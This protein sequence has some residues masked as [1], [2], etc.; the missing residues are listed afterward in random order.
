MDFAS[1]YKEKTIFGLDILPNR[2]KG[3]NFSIIVLKVS[4]TTSTNNERKINEYNEKE[5]QENLDIPEYNEKMT[6]ITAINEINFYNLIGLIRKNRPDIIAI[7]N[8]TELS[9]NKGGI[10]PFAKKIPEKCQ[11]IQVTGSPRQ[12]F[13]K[14]K[15]LA[16][17]YGIRKAGLK[18][19]TP[20]ET[21]EIVAKLAAM[22]IG[23]RMVAFEDE[24]KIAVSKSR[25][26]GKGGWSAPRYERNMKISVLNIDKEIGRALSDNSIDFDHFVYP[27]R[28]IFIVRPDMENFTLN[29]F[30]ILCKKLG[31]DLADVRI[32]RIPKSSIEFVPLSTNAPS[33][34]S[35]KIIKSI[36]V[37]VDPGTTTGLAIIDIKTQK[38]IFLNSFRD[39]GTS[40][41]VRLI[42]Q[43]GK[44]VLI[45]TDVIDIPHTIVRLGKI[46]GGEVYSPISNSTISRTEKREVV[47]TFLEKINKSHERQDSHQRDALFAA[48][49]GFQ[50]IEKI[51]L[52]TRDFLSSRPDLG[53]YFD[54]IIT[55]VINGVPLHAVLN[56]IELKIETDALKSKLDQ[57]TDNNANILLKRELEKI[58]SKLVDL[59]NSLYEAELDRKRTATENIF[60]KN[61]LYDLKERNK[62]IKNNRIQKI[63]KDNRI[64]EKLREIV[65]YKKIIESKVGEIDKAYSTIE[66]LKKFRL[67]WAK[68]NKVPIKA[69]TNLQDQALYL[70]NK[71]L[72]VFPGD[73]IL[74]LD[75]Q[76]GAQIT[77]SNLVKKKIKAVII[78][79]GFL[80]RMSHLARKTFEEGTIPLF[81]EDIITFD[82]EKSP[83][84]RK[85]KI[86]LFDD[87]YIADKKYIYRRIAQAELE[88]IRKEVE[89]KKIQ[90]QKRSGFLEPIIEEK[91]Q[92]EVLIQQYQNSRKGISLVTNDLYYLENSENDFNFSEHDDYDED[93]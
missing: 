11:I 35:F 47:Q 7:D 60:M 42:A 58:Q 1:N 19:P 31:N 56:E 38:L 81:E 57:E 28:T 40:Q 25:G 90:H 74:L 84:T 50:S 77:A 91:Y 34:M 93:F 92:L 82:P 17:K 44:A 59:E 83:E 6:V 64:D 69:I 26:I 66:I 67:I 85:N 15:V 52:K 9:A 70:A 21:A 24:I 8:I 4:N 16:E 13:Q 32:S 43:F 72:G 45:C 33:S 87:L 3:S 49:K 63:D 73:I 86:V 79:K 80:K 18:H 12:G 71:E 14:L 10:I 54:Q 5:N 27:K 88:Y 53:R 37:G 46:L 2:A 20:L 75:P 65:K 41:L 36:I 89:E 39:F 62:K 76:G 51:V 78:P 61:Q 48:L 68:G 23:Y 30:K 55:Q 29:W 22:N